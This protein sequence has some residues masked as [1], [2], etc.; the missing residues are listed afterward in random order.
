MFFNLSVLISILVNIDTYNLDLRSSIFFN[1]IR[2]SR[3]QKSLRTTKLH[4]A[5]ME[6]S[7]VEDE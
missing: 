1:S 7:E 2:G 5:I 6:H 4:Y 3:D